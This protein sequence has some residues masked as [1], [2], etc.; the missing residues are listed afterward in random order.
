MKESVIAHAP[1]TPGVSVPIP[2]RKAPVASGAELFGV[3]TVTVL[4]L[5][6]FAGLAWYARRRGWLDRW[7]TQPPAGESLSRRLSVSEVLHV[8]RKTTVFRI[9][10]GDREWLLTESSAQ[11]NLRL[12]SDGSAPT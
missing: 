11:A 9:R 12:T 3:L 7:V 1:A 2:Y 5:A 6:A 10:D 8:S 4:L